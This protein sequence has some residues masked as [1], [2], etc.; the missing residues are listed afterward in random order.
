MSWEDLK[1]WATPI[2]ILLFL[3]ALLGVG[4]YAVVDWAREYTITIQ[5]EQP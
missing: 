4:G 3:G 5:R 2:G 1:F